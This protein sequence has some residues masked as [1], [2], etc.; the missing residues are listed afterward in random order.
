MVT[1]VSGWSGSE[2]RQGALAEGPQV[3]PDSEH[4]RDGSAIVVPGRME[5]IE[6]GAR[7]KGARGVALVR[8]DVQDLA[9]SQD[10]A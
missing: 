6:D 4:A 1:P 3:E 2:P 8:R 5:H 7:G 9:R 10:V